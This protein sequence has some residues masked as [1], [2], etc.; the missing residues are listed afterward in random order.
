MN[1]ERKKCHAVKW[2]KLKSKLIN[3]DIFLEWTNQGAGLPLSW[4]PSLKFKSLARVCVWLGEVANAKCDD[5]TA[6]QCALCKDGL[7]FSIS[8][9]WKAR[10][11]RSESSL[12]EGNHWPD[13]AEITKNRIASSDVQCIEKDRMRLSRCQNTKIPSPSFCSLSNFRCI[14]LSDTKFKVFMGP[15][16]HML[17]GKY[18]RNYDSS[19]IF[20]KVSKY[21][22]YLYEGGLTMPVLDTQAI[23]P[24]RLVC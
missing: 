14:G 12:L 17:S 7:L 20:P 19:L 18:R 6:P 11:E 22:K 8:I 10:L 24:R 1:K 16:N 2:S 3:F 13:P 4:K 15:F 5:L 23:T 9:L 21:G